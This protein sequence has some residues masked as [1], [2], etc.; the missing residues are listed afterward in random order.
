MLISRRIGLESTVLLFRLGFLSRDNVHEILL[1]QISLHVFFNLEKLSSAD[2][3]VCRAP[4]PLAVERRSRLEY[5]RKSSIA[6]S[7][8]PSRENLP[9]QASRDMCS[10]GCAFIKIMV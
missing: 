4:C 10:S 8:R 7:F 1:L 9:A 6:W 2:L 3:P 5:R